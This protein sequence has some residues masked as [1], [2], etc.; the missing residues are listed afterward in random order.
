MH[1][2]CL[3]LRNQIL[4]LER[5]VGWE[6]FAEFLILRIVGVFDSQTLQRGVQLQEVYVDCARDHT[7]GLL[8][9]TASITESTPHPLHDVAVVVV[10]GHSR[11]SRCQKS[12]V[13]SQKSEV[14]RET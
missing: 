1:T 7:R 5:P 3:R 13:R 11:H 12:E 9:V 8:E 6:D 2:V 4:R 14:R 10:E